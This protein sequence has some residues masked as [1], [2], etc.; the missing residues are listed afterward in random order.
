VTSIQL[1]PYIFKIT[2]LPSSINPDGKLKVE[3]GENTLLFDVKEGQNF[4]FVITTG[5]QTVSNQ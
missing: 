4:Y 3:V 1:T 2:G 5:N